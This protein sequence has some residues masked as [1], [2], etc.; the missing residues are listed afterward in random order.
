MSDTVCVEYELPGETAIHVNI[1]YRLQAER[2]VV[3]LVR[4]I[5]VRRAAG[6]KEDLTVALPNW[7]GT[8]PT[9]RGCR[10]SMARPASWARR[11]PDMKSKGR[12][13]PVSHTFP[14]RW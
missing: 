2:D 6:L 9:A 10:C 14:A 1:T 5:E 8:L 12:C 13:L 11:R 3:V 4:E 7:P